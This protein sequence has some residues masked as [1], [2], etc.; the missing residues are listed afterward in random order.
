MGWGCGCTWMIRGHKASDCPAA[1]DNTSLPAICDER[2]VLAAHHIDPTV[3]INA[4]PRNTG[5]LPIAMAS[6]I[7]MMFPIPIKRVG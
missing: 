7:A 1:N 5:R 2:L 3:R 4:E 6:G